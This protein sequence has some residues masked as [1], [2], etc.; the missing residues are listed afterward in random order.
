MPD[1]LSD[2]NSLAFGSLDPAWLP[3]TVAAASRRVV[4]VASTN[5]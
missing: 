4:A 1:N 2:T 5:L 3:D